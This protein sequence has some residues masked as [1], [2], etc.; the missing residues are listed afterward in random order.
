MRLLS[1]DLLI[2]TY[3]RAIDLKLEEAFIQL[4]LKEVN[5]RKLNIRQ[6]S[7]GA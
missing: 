3:F 7:R 6:Q 1:D 2:D 5:R 4:I